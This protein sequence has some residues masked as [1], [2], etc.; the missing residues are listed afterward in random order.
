V[1]HSHYLIISTKWV[2]IFCNHV[3]LRLASPS[4]NTLPSP[5]VII[6]WKM[7]I[8]LIVANYRA[9]CLLIELFH[10]NWNRDCWLTIKGNLK[11]FFAQGLPLYHTCDQSL[12]INCLYFL[13]FSWFYTTN[14]IKIIAV[15]MVTWNKLNYLLFDS[16]GNIYLSRCLIACNEHSLQQHFSE[17]CEF[18]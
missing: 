15:Q 4:G 12:W 8:Y 14:L 13:L 7:S 9:I 2:T 6:E 10:A 17:C 11:Y 5:V 16:G 3:K 18:S 1:W